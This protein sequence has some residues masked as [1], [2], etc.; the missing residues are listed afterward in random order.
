MPAGKTTPAT[1]RVAIVTGGSRGIGGACAE[2]LA[3]EGL[4]VVINYA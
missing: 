2:C 3:R 1:T 4:S